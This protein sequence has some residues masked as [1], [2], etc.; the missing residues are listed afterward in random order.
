MLNYIASAIDPSPNKVVL[1]P[2]PNNIIDHTYY[3]FVFNL[4][5]DKAPI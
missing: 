2:S 4:C 5:M 1:D 3:N